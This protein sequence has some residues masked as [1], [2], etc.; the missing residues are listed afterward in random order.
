MKIIGTII[1]GAL[2]DCYE[3]LCSIQI[4]R[5]KQFQG[6]K[7]IAF[8][9]DE[10]DM[11]YMLH[12]DL[13]MVD[14]VYMCDRMSDVHVDEYFQFQVKDGEL[15]KDIFSH[16]PK[17]L[18]EKFDLETVIKPWHVIRGHDFSRKGIALGLSRTGADYYP[19]CVKENG[20]DESMFRQK[21]TVGY[22]WRYRDS[23]DAINPVLQRS[24]AW[25]MKTKQALFK[26]LID[27]Y[28]AHIIVA[29][30]KRVSHDPDTAGMLE[31]YGFHKGSYNHKCS[32]DVFD[33]PENNV[34]Y[35]KGLGFA[36]EIKIFS[37]CSVALTMPSG[38]SEVLWMRR[39]NPVFV[40][41]P[42]PVYLAKLFWNR[43]PLFFNNRVKH[44]AFNNLLPHNRAVV[45]AFLKDQHVLPRREK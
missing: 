28:D 1:H 30:M 34:T 31:K 22:L 26:Y 12:Y 37:Q 8:F 10:R 3:Q 43:M 36:E 19:F 18:L 20:I 38:F 35:L 11:K 23:H 32:P 5:E 15:V 13:S 9:K 14:E 4:L 29:G 25:I 27:T 16:L 17:T 21:M 40:M 2:G 24:K 39:E 7:W 44:F 42:P 45:T 6:T 41:D 33:L